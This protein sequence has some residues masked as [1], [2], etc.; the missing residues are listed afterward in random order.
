MNKEANSDARKKRK[1]G[2]N[3][4]CKNLRKS[5]HRRNYGNM[6][7]YCVECIRQKQKYAYCFLLGQKPIKYQ[8]KL[9]NDVIQQERKFGVPNLVMIGIHRQSSVKTLF[10]TSSKKLFIF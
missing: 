9:I 10:K 3:V 1:S 4:A 6:F 7:Q 8:G 5:N 2:L